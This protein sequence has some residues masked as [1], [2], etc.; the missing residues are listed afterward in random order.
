VSLPA[1]TSDAALLVK[2]QAPLRLSDVFIVTATTGLCWIEMQKPKT[3]QPDS[4]MQTPQQTSV[5]AAQVGPENQQT[6]AA[7][8]AAL[9]AKAPVEQAKSPVVWEEDSSYFMPERCTPLDDF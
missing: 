5:K 2:P 7:L 6:T 9:E 4:A 8:L 3:T 1:G